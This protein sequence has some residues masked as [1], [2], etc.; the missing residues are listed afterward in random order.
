VNHS[1]TAR[2]SPA[3]ADGETKQP[4]YQAIVSALTDRISNGTYAPGSRL[5]A[6]PQLCAEFGVHVS[7]PVYA[8]GLGVLAGDL[9]KVR[10]TA[11]SRSSRSGSCTGAGTSTSSSIRRD[12]STSTGR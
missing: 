3:L 9:L 2:V 6:G 10:R 1:R 11:A 8:V 12:G 7:L 4:A 5:P